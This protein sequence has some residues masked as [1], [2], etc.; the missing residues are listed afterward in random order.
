MLRLY[1]EN[2]DKLLTSSNLRQTPALPLPASST[3]GAAS[4]Q[5][6]ISLLSVW[7]L[8]ATREGTH[9]GVQQLSSLFYCYFNLYLNVRRLPQ[10]GLTGTRDC[11][12]LMW[13]Y[14]IQICCFMSLIF[15]LIQIF[16]KPTVIT[17]VYNNSGKKK[18]VDQCIIVNCLYW[19][20]GCW[21]QP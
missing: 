14:L 10:K 17:D 6:S 1:E 20:C 18:E 2:R 3:A 5:R 11:L 7:S 21:I 19:I 15:N 13:F 16:M 8:P 9:A 12:Y 4:S